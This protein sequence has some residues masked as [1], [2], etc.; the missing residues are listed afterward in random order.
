MKRLRIEELCRYIQIAALQLALPSK[1][2]LDHKHGE[3]VIGDND[4]L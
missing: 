3:Q 1:P 2:S 4:S